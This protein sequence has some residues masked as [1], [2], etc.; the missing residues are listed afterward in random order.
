[1]VIPFPAEKNAG[2]PKSPPDFPPRK[3]GILLRPLGC[4]GNPLPLPQSLYRQTDGR[5][6]VRLLTSEPKF[7]DFL[8]RGVPLARFV[9]VSSA[10]KEK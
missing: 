5:A 7:S 3:D 6:G 4:L 10:V 9:R 2:Y 1:M 8:T